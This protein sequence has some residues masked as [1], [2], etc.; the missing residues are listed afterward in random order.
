[1]KPMRIAAVIEAKGVAVPVL[2][3]D[4]AA[5][6]EMSLP[7]TPSEMGWCSYGPRPGDPRGAT[8]LAAHLDMPDYETGPIAALDGLRS[9]TS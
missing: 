8:V 3:V 2:P 7:R 1:M 4:V 9:E 6:G 5:D